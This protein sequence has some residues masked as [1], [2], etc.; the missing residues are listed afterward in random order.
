MAVS[1]EKS[2]HTIR[3]R[4]ENQIEKAAASHDQAKCEATSGA[5]SYGDSQRLIHE[6][7]V[8]QIEL[9]MQNEELRQ[10]AENSLHAEQYRA[11]IATELFGYWLVDITG[12]LLDV[13][14]TYCRM[15]GYSREEL[16]QF[17]VSNLEDAESEEETTRHIKQLI[18]YGVDHF[19][20]RHRA[21]DGRIFEVE[22]NSSYLCSQGK[23][24]VFIRDITERKQREKLNLISREVLFLLG[25]SKNTEETIYCILEKTMN[26]FGFDAMAIRLR[27]GEDM[28]YYVTKGFSK[29]FVSAERYLCVQNE[30]GETVRFE[31]GTPLLECFCGNILSG[32]IN[33]ELPFLS[34]FGSF[35]SNNI[36]GLEVSA[37]ETR[38]PGHIRGRC[39]REGYESVALIPL[40]V[41]E[42]IIG[43]LQFNDRRPN[44]FTVEMISIFE[45]LGTSIGMALS[46]KQ[47]EDALR[48]SEARYHAVIDDQTDMI[49]RYQPDGRLTFVNEAYCRYFGKK[50]VE[51]IDRNFIPHI[52]EPDISNIQELLNMIS[53]DSPIVSFEHRVI[54]SDETVCWQHWEHRGIYSCDGYLLE[55]QAVG[56]DI[57]E[58]KQAE[59]KLAE[60]KLFRETLMDAIPVPIYFKDKNACYIGFNKSF[61]EFYGKSKE[62]LLGKSVYD[63]API[64]LAD[65]YHA[66]D[67]EL[68]LNSGSQVYESEVIDASGEMHEVVFHK[69][70]Y[71]GQDGEVNGL[72]GAI[73]DISERKQAEEALRES[74]EKFKAYVDNSFDIIFVLNTEGV[75]QF[76]SQAWERHFGYS[77]EVA[78]GKKFTSF[79][80]PDDTSAFAE[81]LNDVLSGKMKS[82]TSPPCRVK[83]GAGSWRWFIANGSRYVDTNNEWQF[84]GI[85]RDITER[86]QA[87]EELQDR[88]RQASLGAEVGVALNTVND[89][90]TILRRCAEAIVSHLDAAFARIWILNE[91]EN[92][93][94]LCSSAGMYTHLNGSHGRIPVG[95]FKI[96]LIVQE[97]KPHLTN[98]VIYDPRISDQEW[99]KREGIVAFAGH[100]LIVADKVIG[101]MAIFTRKA[102]TEAATNSLAVIADGIALGIVRKQSEESLKRAKAAADSANLAKSSFLATMS[103]EI[104]TP[105][106]AL[107][108]NI[109]LLSGSQLSP[110]QRERLDDS[111]TASEMLLQVIND[112]LD[113]SK[114]E[115]GKLELVNES[116]SVDSMARQLVRIFSAT[117]KEKGVAVTLSL[118]DNLPTHIV[119]DQHRLRQIIS[120]LISNAIKFTDHGTVSLEI[121]T[122]QSL[123]GASPD[124]VSLAISVRDTGIG[125]PPDKHATIFDS[126]TQVEQFSTRHQT[127][128][129]LG[130]AISRSLIEMMGGTISLSSVPGEGSVFTLSLLVA[131]SQAPPQQIVAK[132]AETSAATPLNILLA[133]D[134]E[135]GRIVTVALLERR[136]HHVTAVENGTALLEAL[137]REKIDIVLSDISMPDMDGME[138][139]RIIRSGERTDID[140]KVPIIALTA[141]A[142]ADEQSRFLGC[143]FNGIATKPVNFEALLLQIEEL[144]SK[145]AE[146][147]ERGGG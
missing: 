2:D 132:R 99:A 88:M 93:L 110:Q 58:R 4:A 130:L 18:E 92:V 144:Y 76:I 43:L 3:S 98:N 13:N 80:H 5:M 69:A 47:A 135:L 55:Y 57:T 114:I 116:F 137:Q 56:R 134:E 26:T 40:R 61:E 37:I 44:Q 28:P 112:I 79:I 11:M 73:L 143:G 141:H 123:A 62:D 127:G 21:K 106:N 70:A 74:R 142:F 19:E 115:S 72:I 64:E 113:F 104:R 17:S 87:D 131:V 147:S 33:P 120:N 102:L 111:Q 12:K 29:E 60:Q 101:V 50:P 41:G 126:F 30:N 139:A 45:Q 121:L 71:L 146:Q 86:K 109:E 65:V 24:I 34:E 82:R 31:N 103:H 129:G 15:S 83:D 133:D 136:G 49:C 22:I 85:G 27:D 16:L 14:D 51:L 122:D 8:H 77:A 138:V 39:I 94:E 7:Q 36:S 107:L 67:E 46:Q 53:P 23:N 1:S 38:C 35:W 96:G 100:P 68:F 140:S 125:I 52:P 10:S 63:L 66:K 84:I 119:C 95:M 20:S 117:A 59:E 75:F 54:F 105:L 118:A 90:P 128:T 48:K 32:W 91:N 81:Y 42:E 145:A 97:K 6:L 124:M 9:E 89:L 78:A 108:G 25:R